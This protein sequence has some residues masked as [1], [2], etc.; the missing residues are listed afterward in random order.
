[1]FRSGPENVLDRGTISPQMMLLNQLLFLHEPPAFLASYNV[2]ARA[3]NTSR[4]LWAWLTPYSHPC[5][6]FI[7]TPSCLA[8]R[9][10][11]VRTSWALDAA[12]CLGIVLLA[13]QS[14]AARTLC[15]A[16][17]PPVVLGDFYLPLGA[18]YS[19]DKLCP[20]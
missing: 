14:V 17:G 2:I 7:A 19:G 1:M 11:S 10:C 16:H 12:I 15:E 9:I 3:I 8:L 4:W 18:L 20:V 6:A 13:L 5:E